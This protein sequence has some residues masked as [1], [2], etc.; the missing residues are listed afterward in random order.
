[1]RWTHTARQTRLVRALP[2]LLAGL[3]TAVLLTVAC[4]DGSGRP[5]VRLGVGATVEQRAL[6]GLTRVTLEELG[7]EVRV[8][9]DIGDTVDVR[10][11][12]LDGDLDLYWDYTGAAWS[13]GLGRAQPSADPRESFEAVRAADVANGLRWYGPTQA[14]ATLALFV[15]A[16][17]RPADDAGTMSWLAGQL[18]TVPGGLCADEDFLNRPAGYAALADAY[19]IA[20]TSVSTVAAGEAKAITSV[21]SGEC[22]AALATATS[23]TAV[24]AGLLPV[25]DDQGVFP[26]FVVAPVV[27]E[28]GRADT[29]A[30]TQAL[31]EVSAR[32]GTLDLAELNAR[33]TAGEDPAEAAADLLGAE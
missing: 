18:A 20:T 29:E 16:A 33:V 9:P 27:R 21:A 2:S 19:A 28:G 10:A 31:D 24:S 22:Y 12:M 7:L 4:T 23:G 30:I 14:N 26:A 5:E 8:V 6:A 1:M 13:L 11:M 25:I 15:R 3:L 32:I 17:E